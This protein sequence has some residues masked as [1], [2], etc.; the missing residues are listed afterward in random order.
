MLADFAF[1]TIGLPHYLT[2][3]AILFSLGVLTM[4]TKRNAIGILIG[5]ELVLNA[6]NLNLVAF[7]RYQAGVDASGQV[8]MDGQVY[9]LF[10]IVLAAAEAAV[11][12]AI[13]MNFY[14]AIGS[15]DVDQASRLRG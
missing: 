9:A 5:V 13:F 2:L 4:I 1:G 14:N 3:A 15:V 10:V 8:L 12:I 7:N 6:A 11:A